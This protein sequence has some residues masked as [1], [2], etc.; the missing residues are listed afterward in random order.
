MSR[1]LVFA[2]DFISGVEVTLLVDKKNK[3]SKRIDNSEKE[4]LE[5]VRNTKPDTVMI[6]GP[7]IPVKN[8]EKYCQENN[9]KLIIE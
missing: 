8:I 6:I 5:E 2:H 3:M 9:I 7:A 1:L 4:I